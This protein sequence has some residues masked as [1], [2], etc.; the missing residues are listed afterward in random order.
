[1]PESQWLA[2]DDFRFNVPRRE[3]VRLDAAGTKVS[4]GLGSRAADLLLLFLQ[5]PGDLV[6]KTEIMNT[7]WPNVAVEDSNLTVQMSALRRALDGGRSGSGC[8]QNVPGRGYRFTV[9]V[10]QADT[11]ELAADA[12]GA[13]A[14]DRAW[15][16]DQ[17]AQSQPQAAASPWWSSPQAA[18]SGLGRI[19]AAWASFPRL[20]AAG[21]VAFGC[22]SALIMQ[23]R[24]FHADRPATASGDSIAGRDHAP[25][26]RL[27]IAVLP[28]TISSAVPRDEELAVGLT[29][30]VITALSGLKG[31]YV[32]A[33]SMA[34]TI[35]ARH[36]ALPAIGRELGV[37]YVLEGSIMHVAN[38]IAVNLQLNDATSGANIW[39]RE[40]LTGNAADVSN[41]VEQDLLFPL[42]TAF[43]DAEAHRLSKQPLA[44][45]SADDLML[46]VQASINHQPIGPAKNAENVAM[47]ERAQALE[48]NSPD[49]MI[50]LALA[51]L[52]PVFDYNNLDNDLDERLPRIRSL[53]ERS[54]ALAAGSESMRYLQA[55]IL[56]VDG[57]NEEALAAF[58]A[59]M[60]A[61]PAKRATGRRSQ[62][63]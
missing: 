43:M 38:G 15:A 2:F 7:V 1:M 17:C 48:P 25:P 12:T 42:S 20:L 60:Q 10:G 27:S 62:S 50:A 55:E 6:T 16:T 26:P 51:L 9:P 41:Q 31:S 58:T 28:F 45:L 61:H 18:L 56:R 57:R 33:R 53:A 46:R 47:L 23:A 19:G 24:V 4:I 54:R 22:V 14:M 32:V 37:R 36:L 44:E 39:S 59:L 34:Q 13:P 5:R 21:L 29:D 63:A 8:I 35:A 30:H 40:A 49:V 52:R 3:L 11:M